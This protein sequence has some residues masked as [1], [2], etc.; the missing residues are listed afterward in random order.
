MKDKVCSTCK[1]KKS[2]GEF[3]KD[4]SKP[5]GYKYYCKAC[6]K[7]YRL[8]NAN[9]MSMFGRRWRDKNKDRIIKTSRVY[10]QNN[11][12][13]CAESAKFRYH[14]NE[15]YRLSEI[16]RKRIQKAIRGGGYTKKSS[17]TEMLGADWVT[18]RGHLEQQFTEG[19]TWGDYGEWHVDH[20]IPLASAETEEELIKLFHYTN[21]QPLWAEDNRRKGS[22]ID[23]VRIRRTSIC[24]PAIT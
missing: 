13:K 10:Y 16:C 2:I 22:L 1:E 4:K 15:M 12:A 19:M 6:Y 5:D 9:K 21:L 20:K 3:N 24:E 18:I 7:R 8:E 23:G 14:N 11:K 17:T